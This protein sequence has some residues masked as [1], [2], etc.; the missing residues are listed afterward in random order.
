MSAAIDITETLKKFNEQQAANGKAEIK[1]G[2][3][4]ASGAVVA[5]Y[6][7]TQ[8]R[9]TYP[10]VGDNV[11]LNARIEAYTKEVGKPI[12][13]DTETRIYLPESMQVASLGEVVLKGKTI[14]VQ[15]YAL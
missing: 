8:H 6:A 1:V 15:V 11:N 9:A 3:G 14:P 2:I 7:G 5:G 10:C 4:I 13:F 12:L